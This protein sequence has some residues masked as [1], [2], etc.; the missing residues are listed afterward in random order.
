[1]RGVCVFKKENMVTTWNIG[2]G[3][4]VLGHV[5]VGVGFNFA[6]KSFGY[7]VNLKV[8]AVA[9]GI[10]T[11]WLPPSTDLLVSTAF[12]HLLTEPTFGKGSSAL[13]L[14]PTA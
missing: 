11:I 5:E 2:A 9:F 10:Y 7:D 13:H 4:K 1:M 12:H 6:F 8:I 14:S 3:I